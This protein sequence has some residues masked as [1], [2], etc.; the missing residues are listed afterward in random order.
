MLNIRSLGDV[1]KLIPHLTKN[2]QFNNI[3]DRL[4]YDALIVDEGQEFSNWESIDQLA[5]P[6]EAGTRPLYV[7]YDPHQHDGPE[8]E[9]PADLKRFSMEL[10]CRNTLAITRYNSKLIGQKIRSRTGMAEGIPTTILH[11]HNFNDLMSMSLNQ[12]GKWIE[13][14]GAELNRMAILIYHTRRYAEIDRPDFLD[15][16]GTRVRLLDDGA[17]WRLGKGVFIGYANDFRGLEADYV[18]LIIP[19]SARA[20]IHYVGA[21]RAREQLVVLRHGASQKY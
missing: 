3:I 10:N 9:M 6:N 15:I 7:F 5:R 4:M 12:I 1:T 20:A 2:I 18:I 8:L 14:E 21:S 13:E 11:S 16:G 17:Q 19:N